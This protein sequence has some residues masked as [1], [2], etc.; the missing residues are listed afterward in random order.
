MRISLSAPD[1]SDA[2]IDAVTAVLRTR[3]LSLGPKL[4]EFEQAIAAYTGVPHA[5][6]VSSGTAGLHLCVRALGLGEGDEVLVPSFTFIAAVNALRYER[7]KPVFVE[8]EEKTLNLDIAALERA[9]TPQTRAIMVVHTFGCPADMDRIR[10]LADRH[11]LHIIE[12]ACEAIGAEWDGRRVGTFG[13]AAVYAFYPNKQITTGEGGC[14]VTRDPALA[15]RVRSLRNQGRTGDD[16]FDHAELGYNYRLS[17]LACA[18][19]VEQMKRLPAI[20][21]RRETIARLYARYLAD[22]PGLILPPLDLP[23]GCI[24]WFVYVVR[25][26]AEG[27]DDL[28]ARGLRDAVLRHLRCAGIGCGRYFAPVHLQSCYSQRGPAVSLPVTQAQAARTVA[29]PFFNHIAAEEVAEVCT[30][31]REALQV[32]AVG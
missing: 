8:I 2:E 19:G 3:Q 23:N 12:D 21:D 13:N 32:C 16:W 14:V 31:L 15:A 5:V 7:V 11:H 30:V 10:V 22:E 20:L 29:L 6:A 9:I 25:L 1:I 27:L 26:R 18:L 17:E 28:A 4:A 24:S